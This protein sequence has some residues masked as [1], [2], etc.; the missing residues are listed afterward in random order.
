MHGVR[1]ASLLVS[2]VRSVREVGLI[3]LLSYAC[4]N[5]MELE[6]NAKARA[7]SP[8]TTDRETDTTT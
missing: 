1:T 7:H 4:T 2:S 3:V 8:R 6:M 5:E